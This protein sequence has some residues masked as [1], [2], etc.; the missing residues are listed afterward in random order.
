MI[1]ELH[2]LPLEDVD[3][4]R[5]GFKERAEGI[6]SFI[7]DFSPNLPYCISINGSWGAG[8]STML[9][10]LEGSLDKGKC[11]TVRFNPWMVSEREELIR[12]LF[13]EIYYA[14]GEGSFHKAKD[15]FFKYAEKLVSPLTKAATFATAYL[16]GITPAAASTMANVSGET[17]QGI[18]DLVFDKPLSKRKHELNKIMD[19]TVRADGQKI[20]I[21]IDELDRLFPEEVITIFQMIKSNL[22]LPGF[23]FVVAMD[24]EVVFDA[25]KEKG[26]SKPEYYLQK[27]FQR[28][29]LINTKYQLMTLT[30]NFILKLLDVENN[31]TH[32]IL[33]E[34]LLAYFYGNI[35]C[36]AVTSQ[37]KASE[38]HN[39]F[40]DEWTIKSSDSSNIIASYED[41]I[42]SLRIDINLHNPRTFLSF[43]E[44]LLEQW[45]N[46]YRYVFSKEKNI[47]CFIHVSFLIFVVHFIYPSFTDTKYIGVEKNQRSDE[48]IP[49]FIRNINNHIDMLIPEVEEQTDVYHR[50]YFPGASIIRTSIIAL[51]KFPD[52][53]RER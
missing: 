11:I 31:D 3:K 48:S 43:A 22:D 12:N 4:D 18:G 27:I 37:R 42:E 41:V 40:E 19:E 32:R 5:L 36:F 7:N 1:E 51:T 35:G 8:K 13:E 47:A 50:T 16:N 17:V 26:I 25:L 45:S 24:E 9:N 14:M 52:Y 23:F 20:V 28:K 33:R 38:Y 15:K 44:L 34:I 29:Y 2:Y 39:D 46:Y 30:D 21:M 49:I 10:F 53:T 6:A